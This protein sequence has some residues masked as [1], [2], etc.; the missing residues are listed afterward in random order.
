[1]I[2]KVQNLGKPSIDSLKLRIPI[3]KLK[4]FD[5]ALNDVYVTTNQTTGEI[6]KEFKRKSKQYFCDEYSFYVSKIKVSTSV[7][8]NEECIVLLLN[9]KQLESGYFQGITEQNISLIHSKVVSLGIVDCSLSVFLSGVVT[10]V[11][12]KKDFEIDLDNYKEVLEGCSAMSKESGQLDVGKRSFNEV[13]NKGI[14]WGKRE[15]NKYISNP[16]T[17]IYHKGFDLITSKENKG[18]KE[19][20]DRYLSHLDTIDLVRIETTVKNKKHFE[21][22]KLGLKSFTLGNVLS[23]STDKMNSIISSAVNKCLSD[24]SRVVVF[25]GKDE[26]SVRDYLDLDHLLCL[27]ELNYSLSRSV[28]RMTKSIKSKDTK[29]R[30]KK[31][32]TSLYNDHINNTDYAPKVTKVNE[33]FDNIGW[34]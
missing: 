5:E 15:S 10:D 26:L 13:T 30:Y 17:K 33:F 25:K 24:R 27:A 23:L 19:F 21:S 1:M 9:S 7:N 22:L 8:I 6:E 11:D 29:S 4:S 20:K 12:F 3:S 34:F 32:L 2:V 28:Q 16:F 31:R 14:Q 18:A